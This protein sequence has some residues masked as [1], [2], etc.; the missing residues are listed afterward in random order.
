MTDYTRVYDFSVKDGLTPGDPNKVIKGSEVDAEFDAL[1]T[2]SATKLDKPS[3]PTAGDVLRY[4][5]LG[6]WEASSDVLTP[7]GAIMPYAGAAAPTGWILCDGAS[8]STSTYADLFAVTGYAFGGAGASFNAPDLRGAFPLGVSG[9][10]ARAAT[11]G[12]A[13]HTLALSET[14]AH[15]HTYS[16]ALSINAGGTHTHTSLSKQISRGSTTNSTSYMMGTGT[17]DTNEDV[18]TASAGSH[19]HTGSVSGTTS[20]VGS[21]GSHNNM[22]PYLALNFII[23][24]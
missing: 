9:T 17:A 4:S 5:I 16:A 11:G 20:A 1:E 18:S 23:K 8:L 3:S 7:V 6:V 15:T 12:A 19:N 22:P 2:S 14:P 13:T 24:V 10:Y 21:S